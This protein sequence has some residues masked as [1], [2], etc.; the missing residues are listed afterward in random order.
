MGSEGYEVSKGVLKGTRLGLS[1]LASSPSIAQSSL[2]RNTG[3]F[4][5]RLNHKQDSGASKVMLRWS[6]WFL[7]V[8]KL[9]Q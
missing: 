9:V 6:R 4:F 7:A 5:D 1:A 8:G 3:Y 2:L